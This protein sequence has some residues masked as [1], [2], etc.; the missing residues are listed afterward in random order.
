MLCLRQ[1]PLNPA[2]FDDRANGHTYVYAAEYQTSSSPD[3]SIRRKH[4]LEV[5]VVIFSASPF[6]VLAVNGQLNSARV[7]IVAVGTVCH[8]HAANG[9]HG[10]AD[11]FWATY[12]SRWLRGE[13]DDDSRHS[14][15]EDAAF[16]KKRA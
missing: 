1:S 16:A 6:L 7:S 15:H 5:R 10:G 11:H 3:A 12:M 2:Q 8:L 14:S 4:D 13:P 9:H